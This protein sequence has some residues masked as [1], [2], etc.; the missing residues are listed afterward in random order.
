MKYYLFDI[1]KTHTPIVWSLVGLHV[2]KRSV[3]AT[4]PDIKFT[5]VPTDSFINTGTIA[6]ETVDKGS[7][8]N[9]FL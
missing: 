2:T 8:M 3:A 5:I 7:T 6:N 9:R 4:I 1:I